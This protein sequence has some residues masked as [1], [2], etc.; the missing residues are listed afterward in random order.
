MIT[1]L[2]LAAI[3]LFQAATPAYRISGTVVREDKQE[4]SR[5]TNGDRIV[6][7]GDAGSV[8][9]DIGQGGAFEFT[10]VRPGKYQ[11]VVGP[12]VIMDAVPVVVTDRDIAGLRVVVPDLV[13][14]RASV[15]V[16]SDGPLPR[17]Q[18]SF[19]R[20]DGPANAAPVNVPATA[21]TF[22]VTLSP[23]L[24]RVSSSGL[25]NGYTLKSVSVDKTDV[26][27]QP[28]KVAAG[29][30]TTIEIILGV[31]SP[32]PWV[33][34][35]GRLT[36][37]F[38]TTTPI[39]IAINGTG[40][41]GGGDAIT[42]IVDD[43]GAFEFAKVLPGSY[44]AIAYSSASVSAP[45]NLK[46]GATDISNVALLLPAPK[47][48]SGRITVQ[49]NF[50]LPRIGFAL[51]PLP[52]IPN[53]NANV[54]VA[55]QP[56]GSFKVSLPLGERRLTITGGL[57]QGYKLAAFT[58]GTSDLSNN[59][60]QIASTD[61]AELRVTFDT[62]AVTTVNVSGRV[63]GLLTTQGVR[64]VL[65]NQAL[66]NVEAA[67]QADGSFAFSRVL[68]GNYNARLSLSGLSA[69]TQ[70]VVRNQDI[71]NV[72]IT[73]PREFVVAGHVIVEGAATAAPQLT[74]EAKSASLSRSSSIV[75]RGVIMLQLKDGEYNITVR[76]IPE[77]FQLKSVMYGTTDLQKSPLKIDGPVT[78]E[79]VVRLV[80]SPR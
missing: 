13:L 54:P 10:S 50:P 31:S 36:K 44:T 35:S 5:A 38:T 26:L 29:D 52:G 80:A 46:I 12:G 3:L 64:V 21:G 58:Y 6:L 43:D 48:V 9:L 49:N 19:T 70:V 40:G 1:T 17:F 11:I 53:S 71:N 75:N 4:P 66:G 69:A 22:S 39:R 34:V 59:L 76:N 78:W 57:P 23:G 74:V 37:A 28:L 7:R 47:E 2:W 15:R 8:T 33:R 41:T 32:P 18:M 20:T 14:M 61:K 67:V 51:A 77:G 65:M 24:Y 55:M 30:L 72:V 56:D 27:A 45:V 63:N 79:I 68:P 73:Y 42:T 62:S 16:E 25:P 60:L